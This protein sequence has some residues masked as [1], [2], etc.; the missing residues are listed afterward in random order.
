MSVRGAALWAMGGQYISF[1]IQ[2]A[3]SVVIS[4]YF[5]TPAEVGL[6][7]IG[8]AAALLVA[9]LQDFGLSRYISGLAVLEHDE[10]AR[11]SSVALMWRSWN[12]CRRT[13]SV[14]AASSCADSSV[15]SHAPLRV[16]RWRMASSAAIASVKCVRRPRTMRVSSMPLA[17]ISTE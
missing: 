8:L 12:S 2:F 17:I 4:R 9:V 16:A 14:M 6:F 3:T 15:G 10:I 5:L 13:A 7:S 11:C 1:A